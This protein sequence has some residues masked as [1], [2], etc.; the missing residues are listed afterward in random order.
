M[1][2]ISAPSGPPKINPLTAAQHQRLDAAL[3]LAAQHRDLIQR[4][5]A[6]GMPVQEHHD[7]N[8][9]WC[10]LIQKMKQLFPPQWPTPTE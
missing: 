3:E 7:K 5:H 9:M 10:E 4:A 8:E 1:S 2:E 6:L